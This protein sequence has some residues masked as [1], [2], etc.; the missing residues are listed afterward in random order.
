MSDTQ[1]ID[2]YL[3]PTYFV[4]SHSPAVISYARERCLGKRTDVEKAIALYYGVRDD[5][6]YDPYSME[7]K[8]EAVTASAVLKRRAGF[9]VPKAVLLTAVLRSRNIPARL[10]FADVRNHLVT[11]RLKAMMETDLFVYHGYVEIFLNGQWVKATPA[12]NLTL[13]LNFNV[14]PLE[15]D[16]VHDSLFHEFDTRGQRHMEY[17]NDHGTFADLPY[18]QI[19]GAFRRHYPK[20]LT[21]NAD[22]NADAF[23]REALDERSRGGGRFNN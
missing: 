23:G 5:I 8:P 18:D 15:F 10:G 13:C 19:Y 9:C 17:V 16:G 22:R 2:Q 4:D 14:K 6:R 7:D 12:F 11:Q 1:G 21:R 20:I 3:E